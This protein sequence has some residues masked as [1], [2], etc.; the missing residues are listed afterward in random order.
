MVSRHRPI[1]VTTRVDDVVRGLRR[2]DT[3]RAIRWAMARCLMRGRIRVVH[4]SIQHDHIHWLIEADDRAAMS[5]GMQGLLTSAAKQINAAIGARGNGPPRRGRV[6]V[7]RYHEHALTTRAEVRHA[8]GY[9][10]GN[11]RHHGADRELRGRALDPYSSAIWFPGWREIQ[12]P[13]RLP[14]DAELLPV[15]SPRSWLLREG[16]RTGPALSVWA[17]PG[18]RRA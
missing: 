13:I 1:H 2:R 17:V 6:F 15:S 12:E 7:D 9:L 18:P 10:L 4:V 3:Y 8:I 11:W 5:R 16:W 14:R